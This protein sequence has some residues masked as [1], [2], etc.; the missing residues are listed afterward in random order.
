MLLVDKY[1]VIIRI[2]QW[3]QKCSPGDILQTPIIQFGKTVDDY[4]FDCIERKWLVGFLIT[5]APSSPKKTPS[6]WK[7][8]DRPNTQ[9]YKSQLIANSLYKIRHWKFLCD[10]Y[11]SIDNCQA[12][13]FIDPPYQYG[14]EY[15]KISNKD[16]NYDELSQ[17][18]YTRNGQVIV[19]E[20]SKATW[21][22]FKP[23]TIMH[24]NKRTTTECMY[25]NIDT[26]LKYK[27]LF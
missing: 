11:R 12:T 19:C 14:G 6:K 10:D 18:C 5:G 23:L 16:I 4:D 22:D 2:W 15:Y 20:N 26:K 13:W 27:N 24:G 25:T 21:M 8:I 3:L 17:G 9:N 7:T 1:D